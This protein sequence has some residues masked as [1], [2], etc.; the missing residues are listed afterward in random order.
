VASLPVCPVPVG[1]GGVLTEVSD[2]PC[3]LRAETNEGLQKPPMLLA[4]WVLTNEAS[5]GPP[6][7]GAE[8]TTCEESSEGGEDWAQPQLWCLR[9]AGRTGHTLFRATV[10]TYFRATMEE[11]L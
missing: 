2:V 4:S 10:T 5:S 7:H 3:V 1:G 11:V 8:C 9:H 6:I